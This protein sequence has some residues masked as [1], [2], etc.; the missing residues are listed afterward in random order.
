MTSR[1]Q[2]A[3]GHF[4]ILFV[5]SGQQSQRKE[6]NLQRKEKHNRE[7]GTCSYLL[8]VLTFFVFKSFTEIIKKN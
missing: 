5:L 3:P 8:F 4:F 6:F 2:E 1:Y 7:A